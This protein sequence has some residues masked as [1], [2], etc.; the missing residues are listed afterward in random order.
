M[1]FI[2]HRGNL[3]GRNPVEENDPFVI[4]YVINQGYDVEI[5]L[6]VNLETLYLGHDTPDHFIDLEWLKKRQDKLWIHCKDY[7]A[8]EICMNNNLHCFFHDKDSYTLTSK[9]YVWGYPG[10]EK[11]S[12]KSILV[13]PEINYNLKDIKD[14]GYNGICSDQI[15]NIRGLYNV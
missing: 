10:T 4:D 6:R 2:S 1:I 3:T 9:Q 14:L 15:E 11:S 12:N 13:L 7:K 5:D 8:L